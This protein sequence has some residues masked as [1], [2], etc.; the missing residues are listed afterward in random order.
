MHYCGVVLNYLPSSILRL[1]PLTITSAATK[2]KLYSVA[3]KICV[4]STKQEI[5]WEFLW[6]EVCLAHEQNS[7]KKP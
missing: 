1:N 7:D 5:T 4:T 6:H 2:I 3:H